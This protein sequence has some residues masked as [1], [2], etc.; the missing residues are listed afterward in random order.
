[1][2][3]R[4]TNGAI[5]D[6][7]ARRK[8]RCVINPKGARWPR[9][10]IIIIIIIIMGLRRTNGAIGDTVARSKNRCVINPRCARW[11]RGARRHIRSGADSSRII[12]GPRRL[13]GAIE[14]TVAQGENRCVTNPRCAQQAGR[15][16]CYPQFEEEVL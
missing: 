9:D 11:D 3:L 6:T 16:A 13:T 14:D 1:M 8:N 7:V 12:V 2:G 10:A 15:A 5:G 4:R